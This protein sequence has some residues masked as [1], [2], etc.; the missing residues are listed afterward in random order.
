MNMTGEAPCSVC[1]WYV[2]T[3]LTGHSRPAADGGTLWE[4]EPDQTCEKCG[5]ELIDLHV[6][7]GSELTH[8]LFNHTED[9]ERLPAVLQRSCD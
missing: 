7:P 3:R 9:H 8:P 6:P 4:C 1:G 5:A 2:Y